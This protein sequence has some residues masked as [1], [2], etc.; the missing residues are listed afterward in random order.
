MHALGHLLVI[1]SRRIS[2]ETGNEKLANAALGLASASHD[3][4][5]DGEE[6]LALL[7]MNDEWGQRYGHLL[8]GP[9]KRSKP[10]KTLKKKK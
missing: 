4:V 9:A 10:T 3:Y 6:K 8:H 5:P 1:L 2:H 7:K